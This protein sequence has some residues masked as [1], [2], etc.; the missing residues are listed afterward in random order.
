M[1]GPSALSEDQYAGPLEIS[2]VASLLSRRI[3]VLIEDNNGADFGGLYNAECASSAP[4]LAFVTTRRRHTYPVIVADGLSVTELA[5]ETLAARIEDLRAEVLGVLLRA[6]TSAASDESPWAWRAAIP[7][8][9]LEALQ[10][11]ASM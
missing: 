7:A 3:I 10:S 8:G 9:A 5:T 2:A 4:P 1:L 6:Q 11:L